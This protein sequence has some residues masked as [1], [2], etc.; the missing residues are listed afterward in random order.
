[1]AKFLEHCN[2]TILRTL[3]PK[4]YKDYKVGDIIVFSNNLDY[5]F[6]VLD[7]KVINCYFF[8]GNTFKISTIEGLKTICL[9]DNSIEYFTDCEEEWWLGYIPL[10]RICSE[11]NIH[12]SLYTVSDDLPSIRKRMYEYYKPIVDNYE[13]ELKQMQVRLGNILTKKAV[14][15]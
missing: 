10:E 8:D 3:D 12:M 1:M 6:K 5:S 14:V 9:Q 7:H 13:K 11:N 2:Y 4:L 15:S